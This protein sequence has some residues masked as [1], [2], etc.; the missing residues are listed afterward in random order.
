MWLKLG[1]EIVAVDL[2]PENLVL[3]INSAWKLTRTLQRGCRLDDSFVGR[4]GRSMA[5]SA[6]IGTSRGL[7]PARFSGEEMQSICEAQES[8]EVRMARKLA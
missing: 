1:G 5:A 7:G 2:I 4:E 3:S 6:S 8:N